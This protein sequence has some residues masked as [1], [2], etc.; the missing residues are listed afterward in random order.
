MSNTKLMKLDPT[1]TVETFRFHGDD[2]QVV[3]TDKDGLHVGIKPVCEVFGI[4]SSQQIQ[5]LKY[6]P[7]ATVALNAT[8]GQDGKIRQ[9]SAVYLSRR[10]SRLNLPTVRV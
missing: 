8:V 5:K 1:V 4:A 2:I 9:I 6:K 7:W 3:I 10:S